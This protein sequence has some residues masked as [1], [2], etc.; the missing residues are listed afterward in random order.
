MSTLASIPF[1]L[2][3]NVAS[4]SKR[5]LTF[6]LPSNVCQA[7]VW[8]SGM[9]QWTKWVRP[10]TSWKVYRK[11]VHSSE[12]YETLNTKRLISMCCRATR[13]PGKEGIKKC[14]RM[15]HTPH[16][17]LTPGR[18]KRTWSRRMPRGSSS[19]AKDFSSWAVGTS[20]LKQWFVLFCIS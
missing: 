14:R 3:W 18:G 20:T 15:T 1:Y 11:P 7:V 9:R 19:I 10:L 4:F 16:Q 8:A 12:L 6:I 13:P 2:H 17:E 5:S